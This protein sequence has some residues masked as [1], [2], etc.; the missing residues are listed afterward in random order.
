MSNT[1]PLAVRIYS[2]YRTNRVGDT[3]KKWFWYDTVGRHTYGPFSQRGSA[4]AVA[5]LTIPHQTPIYDD[6]GC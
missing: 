4:F 6:L 3:Q 1:P 2:E 5:R